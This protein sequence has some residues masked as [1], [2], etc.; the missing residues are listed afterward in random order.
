MGDDD[1]S[2][3]AA[4]L[5]WPGGLQFELPAPNCELFVRI[6]SNFFAANTNLFESPKKIR[7]AALPPT[8]V[9]PGFYPQ[10][11]GQT[12]GFPGFGPG[13]DPETPGQTPG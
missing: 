1:G 3:M 10:T 5:A 2:P 8:R 13:F 12:P 11:P 9:N 4:V 6:G 7:T